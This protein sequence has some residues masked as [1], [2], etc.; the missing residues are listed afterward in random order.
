MIYILNIQNVIKEW[1]SK[2][3]GN[4]YLKI[5]W[6]KAKEKKKDSVLFA[7]NLTK[8]YVI[9]AKLRNIMY[10]LLLKNKAKK[11]QSTKSCKTP[12]QLW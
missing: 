10:E 9:L 1:G 12:N 8:K 11:S 3:L 4:L 7:T 5:L 2:I 6:K